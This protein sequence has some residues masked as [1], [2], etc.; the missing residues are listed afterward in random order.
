MK[1]KEWLAV[2]NYYIW[3]V[4]YRT[5]VLESDNDRKL[6]KLSVMYELIKALPYGNVWVN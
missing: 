1:S 4:T 3:N 6:M 5:C 2:V